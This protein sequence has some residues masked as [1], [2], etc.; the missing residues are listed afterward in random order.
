MAGTLCLLREAGWEIHYLNLSSGNLGS[1]KGSAAATARTRRKEAR[2]AAAL[3]GAV[4]HPPFCSDLEIA[5][6]TPTLRRLCAT[7]REVA[8]TVILT[9]GAGTRPTRRFTP[10]RCPSWSVRSP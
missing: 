7:V 5:Y 4:W 1:L 6:D 8:P 3:L 2:A 9:C 10:G